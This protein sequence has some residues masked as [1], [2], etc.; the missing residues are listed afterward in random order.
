MAWDLP[1]LDIFWISEYF[2]LYFQFFFGIDLDKN[3]HIRVCS[4]NKNMPLI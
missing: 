1:L 3:Y 4:L 2:Y